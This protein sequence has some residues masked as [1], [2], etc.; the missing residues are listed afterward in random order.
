MHKTDSINGVSLYIR[1]GYFIFVRY[2]FYFLPSDFE[3]PCQAYPKINFLPVGALRGGEYQGIMQKCLTRRVLSRCPGAFEQ[4]RS[5][6]IEKHPR[7]QIDRFSAVST[8]NSEKSNRKKILPTSWRSQ[9]PSKTPSMHPPDQ[10]KHNE[11]S[12]DANERLEV[13]FY[14]VLCSA[15]RKKS[16]LAAQLQPAFA[17]GPNWIVLG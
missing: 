6:N 16:P 4:N 12:S 7:T 17:E 14:D 2:F 5:K 13:I 8:K 15:K 11:P 1:L 10:A 9:T 3:R